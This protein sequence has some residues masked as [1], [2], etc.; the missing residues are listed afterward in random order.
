MLI[1]VIHKDERFIHS[2]HLQSLSPF[3][4]TGIITRNLYT[5][6]SR[7]HS[8]MISLSV[9]P[10]VSI[11]SWRPLWHKRHVI[12]GVPGRRRKQGSEWLTARKRHAHRRGS[13]GHTRKL[14]VTFLFHMALGDECQQYDPLNRVSFCVERRWNCCHNEILVC[15][16]LLQGVDFE[17]LLFYASEFTP[18]DGVWGWEGWWVGG[19]NGRWRVGRWKK[20][21]MEGG[22]RAKCGMKV[23]GWAK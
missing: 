4:H 1:K 23:G 13:Q 7:G 14:L 16:K 11:G 2:F 18:D 12:R 21:G 9:S 15:M 8:H 5:F 6:L 19:R 22:G 3:T 10:L 17:R 20:G